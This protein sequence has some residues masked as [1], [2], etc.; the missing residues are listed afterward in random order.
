LCPWRRI[1][2]ERW[3]RENV[4]PGAGLVRHRSTDALR[5]LPCQRRQP[6][7][8]LSHSARPV[9]FAFLAM[10]PSI[11]TLDSAFP[12]HGKELRQALEMRRSQLAQHPAGAARIA[13]CYHPPKTYDVRLHVLDSIAETCGV[14]YI[15]HKDDTFTDSYG[16][17]Y[18]NTG[19]IY[20]A[21]IIY[22]HRT[23]RY[24]VSSRGYIVERH[25]CYV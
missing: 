8:R 25:S 3:Q 16:L 17:D 1:A 9:P 14:E 15:A 11:K 5:L 4:L 21:T 22:D 12:G 23:G 7:H 10:L 19:D 18:L 13:E 24:R 6:R 20:G 2:W